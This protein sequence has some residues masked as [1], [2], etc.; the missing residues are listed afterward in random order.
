M[1]EKLNNLLPEKSIIKN[2]LVS[3]ALI[4]GLA[5]YFVTKQYVSSNLYNYEKVE[6]Y[7]LYYDQSLNIADRN[8]LHSSYGNDDGFTDSSELESMVLDM[9]S[10]FIVGQKIPF[11]NLINYIDKYSPNFLSGK[12]SYLLKP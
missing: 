10:T 4:S 7:D 5:L 1:I 9:D 12:R 11:D 6:H 8:E 2:W 3:G